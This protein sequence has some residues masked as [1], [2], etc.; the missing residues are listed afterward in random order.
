MET[1][2]EKEEQQLDSKLIDETTK[3]RTKHVFHPGK[4]DAEVCYGGEADL[5]KHMTGCEKNPG[6]KGF[7]P[8]KDFNLNCL[9][10]RYHDDDLMSETIKTLAALTVQIKTKFTSLERPEF[11]PDTQ[12]PYPCYNDR[13]SH[14]LRLGTGRV[15]SVEKY[16]ESDNRNCRCAKCQVSATPSKI[17]G[18]LRVLTVSHVVFDDSEVRQTRCVL[19]FDDNKSP[20][21]TLDGWEMRG[22]VDIARD[23]CVF[24]CASCESEA[25]FDELDNL[26]QRFSDLCEKAEHKYRFNDED[27]L[28]IIVSHPH[29]CPK[30]VSVGE[31]TSKY[32]RNGY[33]T[34]YWYTASTCPGSSGAPLYRL[35]YEGW[36]YQ[37]PHCGSDTEGN[38]SGEL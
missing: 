9:P 24:A 1:S 21:V 11:Y 33:L 37:H 20:V 12:V 22:R 19:G 7:I 15:Y 2:N 8:L 31:W 25:L 35:G 32:E 36:V 17:W 14:V 10:S 16:T 13:G 34:R 6:H 30:Y 28:I 27:K 4:H 26:C 38:Y 3:C 23:W 5:H 18:E 29:G